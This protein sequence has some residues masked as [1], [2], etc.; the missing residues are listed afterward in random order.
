M[1]SGLRLP[2]WLCGP[3]KLRLSATTDRRL[4][5]KAPTPKSPA[6]SS[7]VPNSAYECALRFFSRLELFFLTPALCAGILCLSFPFLCHSETLRHVSTYRT[8][9]IPTNPS[10]RLHDPRIR[11]PLPFHTASD[12]RPNPRPHARC[13]WRPIWLQ[14]AM[15]PRPVVFAR[16]IGATARRTNLTSSQAATPNKPSST[17][18]RTSLTMTSLV[19]ER[20]GI[21]SRSRLG[22]RHQPPHHQSKA[23]LRRFQTEQGQGS[24]ARRMRERD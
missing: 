18:P 14:G 4:Q 9:K 20:D 23:Q 11:Y 3:I 10:A 5:P 6:A 2:I 19:Q 8:C 21:C 24:A 15:T 16:P 7:L 17:P 22:T 1:S 12:Q 13:H